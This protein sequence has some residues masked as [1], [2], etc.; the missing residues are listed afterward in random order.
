ML[1]IIKSW[2]SPASIEWLSDNG[3]PYIARQTRAL[4]RQIGLVPRTTL[5]E[6]PQ[7]NGMAEAF[8]KTFKR[9]YA[10]VSPRPDAA[11]VRCRRSWPPKR[12]PRGRSSPT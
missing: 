11:T 5:V 2:M 8:V 9:D 12:L 4:A 7:S 1:S 6:S 3:S 10:R